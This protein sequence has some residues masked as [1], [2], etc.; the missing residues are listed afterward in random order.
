MY[1]RGIIGITNSAYL[2]VYPQL[3]GLCKRHDVFSVRYVLNLDVGLCQVC[4][5]LVVPWCRSLVAGFSLW[6]PGF[7]PISV[8]ARFVVDKVALGQV[9]LRALRFSPVSNIP[10]TLYT[11]LSTI[12]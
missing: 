11:H 8:N 1:G 5:R 12:R 6:S 2:V 7:D 4:F 3:F 9:F 10:P